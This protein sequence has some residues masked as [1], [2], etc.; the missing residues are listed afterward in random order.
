[1][2]DRIDETR[3]RIRAYAKSLRTMRLTGMGENYI[4]DS[5]NRFLLD[6]DRVLSPE[7]YTEPNIYLMRDN[8]TFKHLSSTFEEAIN[9]LRED[10]NW[11]WGLVGCKHPY[12]PG[13]IH[14][15]E[16]WN[17]FVVKLREFYKHVEKIKCPTL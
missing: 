12:A 1:M 13:P 17:Q 15:A 10:G 5:I 7:D 2:K 9:Q 6:I 11:K 14:A 4:H 8:H 16:D 3:K